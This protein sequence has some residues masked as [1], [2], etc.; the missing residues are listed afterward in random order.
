MLLCAGII[1]VCTESHTEH[2]NALCGQTSDFLNIKP[3]EYE[4]PLRQD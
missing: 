4:A 2:I 1:G 3:G